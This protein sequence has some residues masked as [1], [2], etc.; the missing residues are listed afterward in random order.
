MR[1][2]FVYGKGITAHLLFPRR[3]CPSL[4]RRVA[5][6]WL[7]GIREKFRE[8]AGLEIEVKNCREKQYRIEIP[9]EN[10]FFSINLCIH[11]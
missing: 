10:R 1:P 2:F 7:G 8:M 9:A 4:A 11:A 3:C 6:A 5:K